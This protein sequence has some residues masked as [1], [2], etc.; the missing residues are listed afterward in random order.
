MQFAAARQ[1]DLTVTGD[2]ITGPCVAT[3]SIESLPAAVVGDSVSGSFCVG[4]IVS[5]STTVH[6]GG[7]FA[8]RVTGEVAGAHPVL[9]GSVTT[10]ISHPAASTVSIG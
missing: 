6:I 3:V 8:A 9:G 5:G 1:G 10:V 2:V 4:T 7:R